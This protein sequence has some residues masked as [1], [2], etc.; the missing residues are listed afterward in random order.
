MKGAK[1]WLREQG[2]S[3]C[4]APGKQLGGH[5]LSPCLTVHPTDMLD[6]TKLSRPCR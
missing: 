6:G 1:R 2:W 5:V 3:G 4:C